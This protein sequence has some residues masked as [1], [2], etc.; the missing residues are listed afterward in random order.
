MQLQLTLNKIHALL[1]AYIDPAVDRFKAMDT[2]EE[3]EDFKHVLT[4][5]VRSYSFLS[6]IIPFQDIE[7]EKLHAYGK[8]LLNKLP[9]RLLSDRFKLGK[10]EVSLEYYR[11]QKTMDGSI[12]LDPGPEYGLLPA[13]EAGMRK[14]K[15]EKGQMSD[16]IEKINERFGTDFN[17]AD[18]LNFDKYIYE[19][20]QNE[21]IIK[22][23]KTNNLENFK[24]GKIKDIAYQIVIDRMEKD[25]KF[26]TKLLDDEK[27]FN[28]ILFE[29]MAPEAYNRVNL[30][31]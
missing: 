19:L 27:L 18:K 21:T 9:R 15:E 30:K 12:V 8:L 25:E 6:Q 26:V 1:N 4:Q 28:Y 20:T 29:Y 2:E 22:Q 24:K 17:L 23:A 7:L 3:Q 14:D 11:L 31:S 16:I 10:E 13:T 5:F